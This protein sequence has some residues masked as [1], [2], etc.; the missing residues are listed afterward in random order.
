MIFII[1]EYFFVNSILFTFINDVNR[2]SNFVVPYIYVVETSLIIN[3]VK[4]TRVCLIKITAHI[5]HM[6]NGGFLVFRGKQ[7]Y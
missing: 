6:I 2:L 7:I 3:F 1:L 4:P 5:S